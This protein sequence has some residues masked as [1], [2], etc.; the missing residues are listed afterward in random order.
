MKNLLLL[1]G[2]G[3]QEHDVSLVTANYL[4]SVIDNTRFRIFEVEVDQEF[5]W[6]VDG[7]KVE[8]NFHKELLFS[9]SGKKEKI[10]VCV[11]C[12]HGY[13]GETGHIQAFFEMIKLPY[14]GCGYE[15]SAICFNKVLTK[16]WLEKASIPVT[17]FIIAN[18]SSEETLEKVSSFFDE[19]GSIFIK[20]SNQGSSVGCYPVDKKSEIKKFLKEAF[21]FSN[22]VIVEKKI[23][24]RELEIS[25]FEHKGEVIATSPSEIICPDKFYSYE[26]KYSQKSKTQTNLNP[27]LDPQI[28][29][30]I[31]EFARMAFINLK[32]A[33]FCRM[34]F[35]VVGEQVYLNEINTFPGMTPISLFPKMIE[36]YGLSYPQVLNDQLESLSK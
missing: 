8:L 6:S 12:F 3:G 24:P 7:E 10:D 21:N 15:A 18:D 33:Q 28:T 30:T 4:G 25:V 34:D 9:N 11:P 27:D 1:K 16:L 17:P 5:T 31:Q 2:G 14:L 23:V 35:F 19:Q 22:F 29:K 36:N 26:E 32:L 13:P 20:A